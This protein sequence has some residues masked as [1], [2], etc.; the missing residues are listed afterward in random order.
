M[1]KEN[2]IIPLPTP[3]FDSDYSIEKALLNRHCVR[4]YSNEVLPLQDLAQM[5]WACLGIRKVET[6]K[7]GDIGRELHF[8]TAPSAGALYPLEVYVLVDRV[9]GLG[10]GLYHYI[11]GP[12]KEQHSVK[13]VKAGVRS[14]ELADA[15]LGQ[16]CIKD[17][18]V[19]IILTGVVERTA[20]KYGDR[21]ERYVLIEVG[22]AAQNVCLQAPGL[23]I[24]VVMVGAISYEDVKELIG[25]AVEPYYVLSMGKLID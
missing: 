18:A 21:A 16:S 25:E 5:L 2:A 19:N 3:K 7:R 12:G 6:V 17:A 15:A 8:R 23:G 13:L 24:G 4:E 1:T 20:A 10:P 22:H 14:T 11:P 9:E